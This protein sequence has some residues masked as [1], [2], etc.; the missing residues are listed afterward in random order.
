MIEQLNLYGFASGIAA[1]NP[2]C[3]LGPLY[4]YYHPALFDSLSFP[5]EWKDLLMAT[6]SEKG[7]A[8]LPELEEVSEMLAEDI[9][10]AVRTQA[11]FCVLAGDH[12]SA[13]GTWSGA[14]HALREQGPLGLI[15]IDAHMDS[16]TPE[17]SPTQNIHGMPV[18]HLLGKG[19]PSLTALLDAEPK[20]QAAHLCFIGIRSFEPGEAALLE[21]LN[22]KIY[23][24]KAVQERGIQAVLEEALA[25]IRAQVQYFGLT[26]DLDGFDPQDAPGVGCREVGGIAAAQ[27]LQAVKG[28]HHTPGFVGLEI[29]EYNPLLDQQGKTA[30]LIVDL[31]KQVYG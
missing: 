24:M 23:D 16:H 4:L 19:I 14:A 22:V 30:R 15:W 1:N 7:L 2:D 11:P 26:I 31:I 6:S 13:M 27:F 12:S 21:A 25:Y 17:T 28:L 5:V 29:T 8:V 9:A 10:E 18:A 3:G 20:L